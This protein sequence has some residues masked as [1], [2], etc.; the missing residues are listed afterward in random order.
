MSEVQQHKILSSFYSGQFLFS[1]PIRMN[2][3]DSGMNNDT[4]DGVIHYPFFDIVSDMGIGTKETDAR[5]I[6]DPRFLAPAASF[7]SNFLIFCSTIITNFNIFV[8]AD[9]KQRLTIDTLME[10]GFDDVLHSFLDTPM[11]R[12]KKGESYNNIYFVIFDIDDLTDRLISLDEESVEPILYLPMW[13]RKFSSD[14][15]VKAVIEERIRSDKNISID[16]LQNYFGDSVF[17]RMFLRQFLKHEKF[18]YENELRFMV[19][20]VTGEKSRCFS[21]IDIAG[22]YLLNK[23]VLKNTFCVTTGSSY[24]DYLEGKN[25]RLLLSVFGAT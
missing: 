15:E 4:E 24:G 25:K 22:E 3:K 5:A 21:E 7:I 20:Y 1:L 6:N 9:K 8:D 11:Y 12:I 19:R 23:D 10:C 13:Y 2:Q 16:F 14:D 17:L 18:E